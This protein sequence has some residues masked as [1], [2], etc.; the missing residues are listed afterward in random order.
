MTLR[1]VCSKVWQVVKKTCR[2]KTREE[3]LAGYERK[4]HNSKVY[5]DAAEKVIDWVPPHEVL[6]VALVAL[7]SGSGSLPAPIVEQSPPS[8]ST[9]PS[10]TQFSEPT[11]LPEAPF[12]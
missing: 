6:E 8:I 7:S 12:E 4:F 2:C 9:A 1:Q 10:S 11:D 3:R 5:K